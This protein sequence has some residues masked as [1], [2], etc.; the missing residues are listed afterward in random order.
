MAESTARRKKQGMFLEYSGVLAV[1]ATQPSQHNNDIIQMSKIE[2]KL[3]CFST[4]LCSHEIVH[5]N[6]STLLYY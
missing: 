1:T 4:L 6:Q 3:N 5:V 2:K